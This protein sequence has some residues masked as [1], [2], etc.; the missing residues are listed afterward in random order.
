MMK[1]NL[2][3]LI[4]IVISISFLG[5]TKE[6]NSV[7]TETRSFYMGFTTWPFDFTKDARQYTYYKIN[8][9]SDLIAF[10]FDNGIP[11]NEALNNANYPVG[12]NGLQ[13]NIMNRTI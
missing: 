11:W 13:K 3:K 2:F 6:S 7:P 4:I 9:Y 5:C 1:H 8:Q 12:M 10:H